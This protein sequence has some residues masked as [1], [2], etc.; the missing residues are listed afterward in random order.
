MTITRVVTVPKAVRRVISIEKENFKTR[1][2]AKA[3]I[4]SRVKPKAMTQRVM[5]NNGQIFPKERVM[6]MVKAVVMAAKAI[7]QTF[8]VGIVVV[9]TKLQ[10]VG[11]V[12]MCV[13]FVMNKMQH[14]TNNNN[15]DDNNNNNNTTAAVYSSFP[16]FSVSA[17]FQSGSAF[18]SVSHNISCEPRMNIQ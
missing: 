8:S 12:I 9:I 17:C 16:V 2:K 10:I 6:A 1:G 11:K 5:A 18:F 13:K 14:T 4:R 7:S 3:R 15:N